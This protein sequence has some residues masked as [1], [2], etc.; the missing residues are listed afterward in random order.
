MEPTTAVTKQQPEGIRGLMSN[1][2]VKA[3]FQ[4]ILG[5]NANAFISSVTTIATTTKL[6]ECEPKSI[7]GAAIAAASLNLNV[8]PSLG[9]AAIVPYGKSAQFQI[10]SKGLIQLALR[11]GQYRTINVT[12]IYDGELQ[13][14]NRLTGEFNF[15]GKRKS[16]TIVGYAAYFELLNGFAKSLYMTVDQIKAHGKRYSKTFDYA[17]SSWKSNFEGMA[18]K[19][20]LKLLLARY[21]I[22]SIEMQSAITQDQAE[23]S[24]K[25]DL[26]LSQITYIDNDESHDD[27]TSI[28]VVVDPTVTATRRTQI[29]SEPQQGTPIETDRKSGKNI[30]P[31]AV[32]ANR[33]WKKDPDAPILVQD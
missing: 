32:S 3:K 4:E 6:T 28:A 23:M 5:K 2:A 17:G 16:D 13:N 20:V 22:L 19:T 27:S 11:S 7:L 26:E 9:F 30:K 14:E 29:V 31:Q 8:T 10:M 21:G 1:E 18:R 33:E 12:E 15:N 25:D 24:V